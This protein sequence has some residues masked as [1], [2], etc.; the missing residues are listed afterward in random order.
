MKEYITGSSGFLGSHLLEHLE[1]PHIIPHDFISTEEIK[2]FDYFYFLSAYGNLAGHDPKG[3]DADWKTLK[4]NVFDVAQTIDKCKDIVF[5]SFVFISTSSVK[6]ETQ[7]MY[8][9]TKKAAEEILLAYKEK[10]RLP[11]CIIRPFSVTGVGEQRQ[12]LIPTLLNAA[13]TGETV[14]FVREPVH[15]FI[16]V[17]DF[18][19]GVVTLA[20]AG[21]KGIYELGSGIQTSN[22]EVLETVEKVTGKRININLVPSVRPYDTE[23]WV[24]T[25]LKARGFG[26][27][28][29][30]TLEQSIT[31][32][33]KELNDSK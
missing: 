2:P 33:W 9:R 16:D 3:A 13:Q 23:Q 5:K 19:N 31:E 20:K 21:A 14:N 22:Q 1:D 32:M 4:A 29:T 8:S 12:H 30:K 24:S 7:T 10:Y 11:V 18:T 28:P 15:D 17:D 27:T 6:L 25:N 26:W